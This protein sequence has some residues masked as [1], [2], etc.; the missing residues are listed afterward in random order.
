MCL[1]NG[2]I[3]LFPT[4]QHALGLHSLLSSVGRH[5]GFYQN[6]K[7]SLSRVLIRHSQSLPK[8][9]KPFPAISALI[10]FFETDSKK[11]IFFFPPNS[12]TESFLHLN[13]TQM[14][15][16]WMLLKAKKCP[17][18]SLLS[19]WDVG[20]IVRKARSSFSYMSRKIQSWVRKLGFS[21]LTELSFSFKKQVII[22]LQ[23]HLS[24][25]CCQ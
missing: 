25:L 21:D 23:T 12:G 11:R 9:L 24:L 2:F 16:L 17:H 1:L 19:W 8:R 18:R 10:Q 22:H 7:N 3:L 6:F 20:V 14:D 4:C 13:K 15:N 5:I